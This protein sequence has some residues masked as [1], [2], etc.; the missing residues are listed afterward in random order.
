MI[1]DRIVDI[2]S[3]LTLS[4]FSKLAEDIAAWL[5]FPKV[6]ASFSMSECIAWI[7]II[8]LLIKPRNIIICAKDIGRSFVKKLHPNA[9]VSV[10]YK[11]RYLTEEE[12]ESASTYFISIL[13][14]QLILIVV[15]S[16]EAQSVSDMF[17]LSAAVLGNSGWILLL[18]GKTALL[19]GL[20]PVMKMILTLCFIYRRAHLIKK[21]VRRF[22]TR[23]QSRK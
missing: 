13:A 16:F 1:I 23:R 7:I 22:K 4:G 14:L 17:T 10:K 9:V 8:V 15:L 12:I 11:G 3:I 19:S 2:F 5:R 20:S 6:L 18:F 21:I